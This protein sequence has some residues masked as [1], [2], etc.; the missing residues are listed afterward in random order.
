MNI[1]HTCYREGGYCLW[2]ALDCD[3][4]AVAL[5]S[6]KEDAKCPPWTPMDLARALTTFYRTGSI[7]ANEAEWLP[8]SIF[9]LVRTQRLAKTIGKMTR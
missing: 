8:P 5:M 4:C 7:P 9:D 6:P 2:S 1:Q 3:A